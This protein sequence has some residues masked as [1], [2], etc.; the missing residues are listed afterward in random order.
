MHLGSLESIQDARVELLSA[1]PRGTLT[2]LSCSANFLLASIT[3]YT[4]AKHEPILLA[5]CNCI[6]SIVSLVL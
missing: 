6:V 5:F 4:N 3:R 1:A 2:L